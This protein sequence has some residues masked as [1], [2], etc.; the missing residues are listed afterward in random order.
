MVQRKFVE[1]K[2]LIIPRCVR[3]TIVHRKVEK[4]CSHIQLSTRLKISGRTKWSL[5]CLT[6]C[7]ADRDLPIAAESN[8]IDEFA[9]A[10]ICKNRIGQ[11]REIYNAPRQKRVHYV[12]LTVLPRN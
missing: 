10:F 11:R 6:C 12:L 5:V 8:R 7:L 2:G 4:L 3:L 9:C 1:G